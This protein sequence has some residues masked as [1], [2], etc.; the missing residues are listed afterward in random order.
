M[1]QLRVGSHQLNIEALRGKIKDPNLRTCIC[2]DTQPEDEFHFLMTCSKFESERVKLFAE[3]TK[4]TPNFAALDDKC[5][6]QWI[7][8]NE[9]KYVNNITANFI[10]Q[11]FNK[12]HKLIYSG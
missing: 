4:I 3:I 11:S 2:Q 12:R 10:H 7:L 6:F 5:K 8:S 1:T 9:D